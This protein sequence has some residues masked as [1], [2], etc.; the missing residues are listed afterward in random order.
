MTSTAME[1]SEA[2]VH[3]LQG[4]PPSGPAGGPSG[5]NLVTATVEVPEA[6]ASDLINGASD[7]HHHHQREVEDDE[8]DFDRFDDLEL[9]SDQVPLGEILE[10]LDANA[11]VAAAVD[12]TSFIRLH[13]DQEEEESNS[14][15][16]RAASSVSPTISATVN[17]ATLDLTDPESI[18]RHLSQLNDTV[19]KVT[20]TCLPLMSSTTTSTMAGPVLLSSSETSIISAHIPSPG[21]PKLERRIDKDNCSNVESSSSRLSP[22]PPPPPNPPTVPSTAPSSVSTTTTSTLSSQQPPPSSNSSAAAAPSSSQSKTSKPFLTATTITLPTAPVPLPTPKV[23]LPTSPV[24]NNKPKRSTSVPGTSSSSSSSGGSSKSTPQTCATCSKTFSNASALAKHRLTHSEERR[25]HCNICSK[26]FKRQDHLNG[27]LLTHRSTKPFACT[28]DGC[29]KSY[30][31]ARSLRRHK[32]NHHNVPGKEG[33]I[34]STT[35]ATTITPVPSKGDNQQQQSSSPLAKVTA[36]GLS[37]Q[38]FQLIEQLFKDSKNLTSSNK[39][40]NNNANKSLTLDN[41]NKP[42]E[43]TI[44]GRKFKNIPALNGHMRLHGGYYKKDAEGR[45]M[46][47]NNVVQQQQQL[48]PLLEEGSKNNNSSSNVLKRK[49]PDQQETASAAPLSTFIGNDKLS[50]ETVQLLQ[51]QASTTSSS[52]SSSTSS[53]SSPPS[54]S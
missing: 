6:A 22:L 9:G 32:E 38:Q 25:Y 14:I 10:K 30:C 16:N 4:S 42:V 26:A 36:K 5:A 31:D 27:H 34:N 28:A 7:N 35:T 41:N 3:Q 46:D 2:I 49:L 47:S 29:G 45:R 15:N 20:T 1:M 51:R 33:A 43:C 44:C 37:P 40:D 53:T 11:A 19:L 50:P 52:T 23:T 18:H 8:D 48:R 39:T 12:K 13:A 24:I 21:S 17:V 54:Y